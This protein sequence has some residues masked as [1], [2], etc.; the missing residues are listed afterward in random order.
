MQPHKTIMVLV[1]RAK[2]NRAVR[3]ARILAC[4]LRFAARATA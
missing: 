3:A 2:S 4:I 1:K